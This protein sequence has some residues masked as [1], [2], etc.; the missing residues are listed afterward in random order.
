MNID[1]DSL[2]IK[3]QLKFYYFI[4]HPNLAAIYIMALPQLN[5]AMLLVSLLLASRH[6]LNDNN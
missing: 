5:Y 3:A 1:A 6:H 2:V 4:A